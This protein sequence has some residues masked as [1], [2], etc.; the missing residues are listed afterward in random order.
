MPTLARLSPVIQ[1]ALTCTDGSA[2]AAG[3]A[4]SE[5]VDWSVMKPPRA[6]SSPSALA[7]QNAVLGMIVAGRV[8]SIALSRLSRH[9]AL[10]RGMA[11]RHGRDGA[12]GQAILGGNGEHDPLRPW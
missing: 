1:P 11:G 4:S 6:L 2:S 9:R 3:T 10:L 12:G 5:S 7:V 8:L